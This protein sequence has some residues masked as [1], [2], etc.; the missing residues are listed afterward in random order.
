VVVEYGAKGGT[1]VLGKDY[2]L[3]AG[4]L[5]FEPGETTKTLV[6]DIKDHGIYDD[7]K[8][9]E[10]A[11]KN[12]KNAV[13]G[14]T[15]VHT[16]TI[17]ISGESEQTTGGSRV[18][19]QAKETTGTATKDAASP[20]IILAMADIPGSAGI[21]GMTAATTGERRTGIPKPTVA[22]L[23]AG[24]RG[25]EKVSSVR[26]PVTLSAISA[27]PVT[28]EYSVAGGTAVRGANY[29][30]KDGSLTFK[31]RETV[32]I[33][34]ISVKDNGV[35]EPDKTVE[36]TLKNPRGA[37][38]GSMAVHTYTIMDNDPEPAVTFTI[39]S[40][41][42]KESAG[43]AVIGVELSAL[44]GWD[45]SVPIMVSGTAKTPSNYSMTAG[46]VVI[47]AGER[48]A[49][50]PLKITD[51]GLNEDD[52]TVTVSMGVPA[53]ALQGKTTASTVTIVNTNPEPS[54][55][56]TIASQQVKESEGTVVIGVELSAIS[57]KDV[58][59]PIMVSG[60]AR[61]PGN[62]TL[63]NGPVVITAGER[64]ATLPV[65]IMDNGLNE[66]DKTVTVSMGVPVRAVQGK[67]TTSAVTIIDDDPAPTV[68]FA[69]AKSR[70][71]PKT[72]PPSLEVKLSAPSKRQVT[73]AYG[74]KGGTAV[75][76]KDYALPG[77]VLVFLPGETEKDILFDIKKN[78]FSGSDRT[79]EVFLMDPTGAGPSES[80]VRTYTIPAAANLPKPTVAFT[81]E[82]QRLS[83]YAGTVAVTV[84]LSAETDQDVTVPFRVAGTAVQ[85]RD[86][87]VAPGPLV[88]KTGER[89]ATITVTMNGEAPVDTDKILEIILSNPENALLGKPGLYRLVIVKDTI[90]TIAVVPFFNSSGKN[91]AGNIM[92]LQFVKELIKLKNF[93]VIEPGVI[94][95]QLLN[96]RVVMT[97]GISSADID[98]ITMNVDADLILTGKVTDYVDNEAAWGQPRVD[99]AVT[100]IA[101][102][103]KKIVW[104]SKSNN[105]GD[106]GMTLFEWGTVKTANAMVSQMANIVR[107]MMV[108]W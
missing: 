69:N 108:E 3:P 85:G 32:K 6:V 94:R 48:S 51:N 5:T 15:A 62:Y 1:A 17:I 93:S 50:L 100:L 77:G 23:Y 101:K 91:N 60:T 80:M 104:S 96:M 87:T 42:A 84:Q 11:L 72:G 90:P 52:K 74:V 14:K 88:I 2:A 71:E 19:R 75:P 8:T 20:L 27:K 61:T 63:P 81:S 49:T 99:F 86:Y 35:N 66:D 41:Q 98:L 26:I 31:P 36:V 64:S 34:E 43:R 103:S 37:V 95:Q 58:T 78:G 55:T 45:V 107:N 92:M 76:G 10:V 12:P 46:P 56:F 59:V 21:L 54:V 29:T 102:N 9:L 18:I 57:G 39:A 13:L 53:H 47:K 97:E 40:Q 22:F 73:V 4:V 67:T 89:T 106:D 30:L 28:V 82:R 79:I 38:L 68:T 70:R 83:K 16:H 65:K 33:I 44:S 24:S 105:T 25:Y 7:D